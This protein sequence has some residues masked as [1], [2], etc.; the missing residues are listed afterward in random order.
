[1]KHFSI[2][3]IQADE[4]EMNSSVVVDQDELLKMHPWLEKPLSWSRDY[5]QIAWMSDL[6]EVKV[7]QLWD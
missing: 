1:M 5:F 4:P 2:E 7:K 3:T 6:T